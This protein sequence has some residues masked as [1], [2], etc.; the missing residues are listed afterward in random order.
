LSFQLIYSSKQLQNIFPTY[1]TSRTHL[2]PSIFCTTVYNCT[3]YPTVAA[4]G[5]HK[6]CTY[7]V[8]YHYMQMFTVETSTCIHTA[9]INAWVMKYKC[10]IVVYHE[11]TVWNILIYRVHH[12]SA[13]YGKHRNNL[14][15]WTLAGI[16]RRME[17]I[18]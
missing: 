8:H 6:I 12:N 3:R 10:K 9:N 18:N 13:E 11:I 16:R 17:H 15:N 2:S 7:K 4:T 5:V 14:C 1:C